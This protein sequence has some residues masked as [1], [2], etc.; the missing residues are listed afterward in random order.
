MGAS[1]APSPRSGDAANDDVEMRIALTPARERPAA[2]QPCDFSGSGGTTTATARGF[3]RL[4]GAEED[5]DNDEWGAAA[6]E[7]AAAALGPSQD[8][9]V[10]G[11]FPAVVNRSHYAAPGATRPGAAAGSGGWRR[12]R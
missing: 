11:G 5:A 8:V 2:S 9:A 7:A 6:E 3:R 10:A 1:A 4:S 12:Q